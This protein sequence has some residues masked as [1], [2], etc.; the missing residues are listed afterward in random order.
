[1]TAKIFDTIIVGAGISGLACAKRLQE[2]DEDFLLISENIGGRILTSEDGTVNYGAFFVCYDYYH[3]LQYVT[4]HSRIKLSDFC[5]HD[6]DDI[7]VLFEPKLL[8]YS[9]QFMKILKI[10]YKFR[11]AFRLFRK[12]SETISQKKAIESD[13]FLHELYMKNAIDFVK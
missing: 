8:A 5:F 2:Y 13:P 4:L 10:L 7:Y 9:F 3:V 1:M 6:N 12:T 11:K